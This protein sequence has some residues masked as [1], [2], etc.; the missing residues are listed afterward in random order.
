[1]IVTALVQKQASVQLS[2]CFPRTRNACPSHSGHDQSPAFFFITSPARLLGRVLEGAKAP[3]HH[4]PPTP[5]SCAH[6]CWDRCS[7][8]CNSVQPSLHTPLPAHAS[9]VP[10][11]LGKVGKSFIP[12]AGPRCLSVS[13]P[14]ISLD[15]LDSFLLLPVSSFSPLHLYHPHFLFSRLCL[16]HLLISLL[17]PILF[18]SHRHSLCILSTKQLILYLSPE[19]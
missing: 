19:P 10:E 14:Q 12:G 16:V 4:P 9:G 7:A 18:S 11:C 6:S 1:M 17:L 2:Q 13:L 8:P 5:P 3:I 15:G